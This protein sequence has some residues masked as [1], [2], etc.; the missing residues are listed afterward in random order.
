MNDAHVCVC[1]V[2]DSRECVNCGVTST[3]LWRRD[4]SGHYLCNACGLYFKM[5]GHNRPLVKPKRK[6]VS[7]PTALR[8]KTIVGDIQC[9]EV[10]REC[11]M[12]GVK[13]WLV[14]ILVT[15][16]KAFWYIYMYYGGACI[17]GGSV[18]QWYGVG[19]DIERSRFRLPDS[20]LLATQVNSAFHLSGVGKSSTRLRTVVRARRVHLCRV[21][22]N[23]VWSHITGDVPQLCHGSTIMIYSGLLTFK[24]ICVF[25]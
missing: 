1:A 8:C 21:A 17:T 20:A 13:R 18:V 7:C 23:I 14:T 11:R 16:L 22:G 3:P 12:L 5:N 15:Y 6:P 4:G 24:I 25:T 10:S 2:V 9:Q 19:L